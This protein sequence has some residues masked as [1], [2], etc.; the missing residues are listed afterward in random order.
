MT[1]QSAN[2]VVRYLVSLHKIDAI[3]IKARDVII[4]YSII[5]NPGINGKDL[6][7]KLAIPERSH[8]QHALYKLE[9]LGYIID[10]RLPEHRRK[11]N[12]AIFRPTDQGIALWNDLKP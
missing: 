9:K 5:S 3:G 12:P 2:P 4:L 10:E 8:I 7:T 1:L 11:A 6:A